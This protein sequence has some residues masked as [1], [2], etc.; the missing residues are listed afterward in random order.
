MNKENDHSC[1]HSQR[2]SFIEAGAANHCF[3]FHIFPIQTNSRRALTLNC[4]GERG[5]KKSALP[6]APHIQISPHHS[7]VAANIAK[8]VECEVFPAE[9]PS[10]FNLSTT[11]IAARSSLPA[12]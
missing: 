4:F 2:N 8:L 7:L 1:K 9:C 12:S 3:A 11:G 6:V 5:V 10:R